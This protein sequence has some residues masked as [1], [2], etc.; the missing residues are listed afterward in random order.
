MDS[1]AINGAP[2]N[3]WQA[4]FVELAEWTRARLAIKTDRFGAYHHGGGASWANFPLTDTVLRQHFR[5]RQTIGLGSISPD[6]LCLWVA[7]DM[8]NHGADVATDVNFKYAVVLRDRLKGLGF[9]ALLLED[10]DGKGSVHLWLF[11]N[12]PIPAKLAYQFTRWIA[13]DYKDH[14][15]EKIE[16]FPKSRTSATE[17]GCGGGY[18]RTPGKHHKRNHWSRFYGADEWLTEAESVQLLL[19]MTGDSAALIPEI[20]EPP[21][22]DPKPQRYMAAGD[23]T[24]RDE[25]LSRDALCRLDPD[26]GYD[27]WLRIGAALHSAGDHML[28]LWIEWS[29]G[30]KDFNEDECRDKWKTFTRGNGGVTLGTLFFM[31]EAAGWIRPKRKYVRKGEPIEITR[32]DEG[33]VATI[34]EEMPANAVEVLLDE[35]AV[36]DKVVELLAGRGDIFDHNGSLAMI[37]DEYIDGEGNRKSIQHLSLA[38]L[39]ELITE[40]CRFFTWK[41]DKETGEDFPEWQRVPRWTYEAI[42]VRG[43]W[44]GIRPLRGLVTSPVLRADG[45]ILQAEGYDVDSGLYVDLTET[46]PDIDSHP[47]SE[48][49]QRAVAM[50]NDV[51]VDF[52]FRDDACR[53]AWL[54]SLLTPLAREAY[55]GCTGPLFLFDANT[56][57]SGKGLLSDV[58]SLIVMGRTATRM[59]A[60]REDEEFRKRITSIVEKGSRIVLIDNIAGRF[61]CESLDAALTTPDWED[62]RLGT[63]E[64]IERPLRHAWY[65]TGNN[66]LLGADTARRVCHIRL[67]SPLE[68]PEDREGFK[69]PDIRGH[70]R[71]NRPALLTAAL[72]ILRG[73]IAA[74]RP[75]QRL[76][77]WGSFEEWS[78]LVRDSIV[79]AGLADPGGTRTELRATSDSEAGALRQMLMAVDH[80]DPDGHGLRTSDMLKIATGKDQSY[81]SSDSDMLREGIEMFCESSIDRVNTRRLGVRLSHFKNRVCDQMAFDCSIK[82]GTNYWFVQSHGGC[83]VSGVSVSAVTYASAKSDV[84][85]YTPEI[86]VQETG[87]NTSTTSTTSTNPNLDWLEGSRL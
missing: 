11:F 20:P 9:T 8:D 64:M 19:S 51:V 82:G 30:S 49:V 54:A 56:R 12:A 69:Y 48:A 38:T 75:D 58:S 87:G 40:T 24:D 60:P 35:K 34:T 16:C 46:F 39:R 1:T 77:P 4:A 73:F 68:N 84:H 7:W 3:A 17:K 71:K 2:E 21:K 79:W 57:G 5:G 14:G 74:G 63:N 33:E 22:P 67:V 15:L 32:N 36:N 43:T 66:V 76:K 85:H 10:S 42:M 83:G 86:C 61:G 27:D 41:V 6:D 80:I 47:S 37:V 13:G 59:T 53:S 23:S 45:S 18:L 28:S 50:L 70:I 26:C 52:P 81:G 62:R 44:S 31:A 78:A 72:T 29:A 25:A 55:R 65:A